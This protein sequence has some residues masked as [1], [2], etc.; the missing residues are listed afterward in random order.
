MS[1][2]NITIGPRRYPVVC[3]DGEEEQVEKLAQLIRAKYDALGSARTPRESQNL[4]FTA[5][6]LADELTEAGINS[7][8]QEPTDKAPTAKTE[9]V[10]ASDREARLIEEIQSLRGA[11]EALEKELERAQS[12]VG[13]S[14]PLFNSAGQDETA[15]AQ[16]LAQKLESLAARAEAAADALEAAG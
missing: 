16:K 7:D 10:D 15:I 3:G 4:L 8:D 9:D 6:L 5:L 13:S 11:K 2:V 14:A 12:G 1:T